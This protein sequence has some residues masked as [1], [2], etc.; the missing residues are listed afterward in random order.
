MSAKILCNPK[1]KL[2]RTNRARLFNSRT[3]NLVVPKPVKFDL[4]TALGLR[5]AKLNAGQLARRATQCKNRIRKVRAIL[6]DLSA[7]SSFA[8]K[9]RQYVAIHCAL[10][11]AVQAEFLRRIQPKK[12]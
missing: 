6:A 2:T 1:N 10:L 11:S 9:L 3:F 5:V 8:P 7:D 4:V 12:G